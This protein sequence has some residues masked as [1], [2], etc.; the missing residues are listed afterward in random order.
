MDTF[1]AEGP[2]TAYDRIL[3]TRLGVAAVDLLIDE[4]D[5]MHRHMVGIRKNRVVS[6]PLIEVVEKS[7]EVR[8]QIEN[9]D[10]KKA[11]ELRGE[12][13]QSMLDLVNTLTRISPAQESGERGRVVIM[14]GG[15]DAPGMNAALSIAARYL[16]NQGVQVVGSRDEFYGLI[17]G[18]FIELDWNELV[19]WVGHPSSNIGTA[20]SD[21]T[22][23][24][25]GRIAENI[26][27]FNIKGIIAIGGLGHLPAYRAA[28]GNAGQFPRIRYPHHA[29]AGDHR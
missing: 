4:P 13:F 18:D 27:K 19:G 21:L 23:E 3:S 12:T 6:T 10:F 20:R 29:H 8:R 25:F 7:R 24:D 28:C 2:P 15:A 9:G 11:V 26:R 22:E 16:L 1:S 14:T 17:H 5:V